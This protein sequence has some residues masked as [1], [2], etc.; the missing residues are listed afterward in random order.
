[1]SRK[2]VNPRG[3]AWVNARRAVQYLSLIAFL[4]LFLMTRQ[5]GWNGATVNLPLRLD[6]LAMLAHSLA[7]RTL[8]SGA[9]LALLT[10]LLTLIAGR[11][12]CGWL[13][14]LGTILDLFPLKAPVLPIYLP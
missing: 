5:G 12:W 14:P 11:A 2:I 10:I 3:H 7:G 4:S 8:L 6:P 1:M 13:C 9:T